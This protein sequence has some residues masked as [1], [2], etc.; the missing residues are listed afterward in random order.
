M[1][2]FNRI[3][4]VLM[5]SIFFFSFI[6]IQAQR[7]SYDKKFKS[8]SLISS[9]SEVYNS[10]EIKS[11]QSKSIVP[12]LSNSSIKNKNVR[13]VETKE[14]SSENY[15]RIDRKSNSLWDGKH[16]EESRF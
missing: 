11:T 1:R 5:I 13:N 15:F 16:W 9:A 7:K 14:I 3:I 8:S 10:D 6:D 12:D 4:L 2:I